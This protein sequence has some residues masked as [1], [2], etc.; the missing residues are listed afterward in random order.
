MR[1]AVWGTGDVGIVSD[2]RADVATT[3]PDTTPADLR[4][5]G[6]AGPVR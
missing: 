1:I 2:P 3:H 5:S 6:G 4:T